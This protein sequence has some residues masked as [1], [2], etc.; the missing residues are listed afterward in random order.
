MR[1]SFDNMRI[2][3]ASLLCFV[4]GETTIAELQE[5]KCR[6]ANFAVLAFICHLDN[7]CMHRF[8]FTQPSASYFPQRALFIRRPGWNPAVWPVTQ[9]ALYSAIHG[10]KAWKRP[11]CDQ[12]IILKCSTNLVSVVMLKQKQKHGSNQSIAKQFP[13]ETEFIQIAAFG[14]KRWKVLIQSASGAIQSSVQFGAV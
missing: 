12:K 10:T 7:T 5:C 14:V 13:Y 8:L 2:V 6:G 9:I 1:L 11:K 4:A 3:I